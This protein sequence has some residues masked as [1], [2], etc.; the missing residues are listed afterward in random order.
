MAALLAGTLAA[1][2]LAG[3]LAA[4]TW[5][6]RERRGGRYFAA[7]MAVNALW[8]LGF[9]AEITATDL[10]AA[11]SWFRWRSAVIAFVP[12]LWTLFALEYA[13]Y[14]DRISPLVVAA[15][16]LPATVT[17]TLSF[18]NPIHGQ[19]WSDA[20]LV[21]EGPFRLLVVEYG[22]G[23]WVSVA[24]S[25]LFV[26]AGMILIA[27]VAVR[28]SGLYRKQSLL[29]LGASVAPCV[30]NASYHLG[31][32]P[33]PHLD[34]TPFGFVVNGVVVFWALYDYRLFDLSPVA[35]S[36]V[37]DRM[38]D[39]VVAVD[40]GEHVVDV[41]PAARDLSALTAPLGRQFLEAFPEVAAAVDVDAATTN[42][43]V[44][45]DSGGG[46][47]YFEPLVTPLDDGQGAVVI[48]RDVTRRRKREQ[49]L[50]AIQSASRDLMRAE[51]PDAVAEHTVDAVRDVLDLEYAAIHLAED[52]ELRPAAYTDAVLDLYDP[53]PAFDVGEGLQGSVFE[54]G[55]PIVYGDV[56]E[57]NALRDDE[58][59]V[60]GVAVF[61]LGDR[62]TLGAASTE[63]FEPDDALVRLTSV[64]ADNAAAALTR[65][66]REAELRERER[67]LAR[68]NEQLDEFA[69]VVSHDLRNPIS[70]ADGYLELAREE[71]D[72]DALDQVA[73]AIDRMERLT[74][75][76]LELARSGRVVTDPAAVSLSDAAAEAWENVDTG[77]ARLD[78]R[79]D[80]A[81][82][83]DR[84]RL[85]QL[86]ENLFRNSVEHGAPEETAEAIGEDTFYRSAA[87]DATSRGT[88][89]GPL[90][91]DAAAE[92]AVGDGASA[93]AAELSVTVGVLSGKRAVDSRSSADRSSPVGFYVEDDG[94]GIPPSE[95][96]AVYEWGYS[97]TSD[98]TGFG[99]AIVR[100]IAEAHGWSVRIAD[101]DG[102]DEPSA[103]G[104][105]RDLSGG[106]RFEITGV[107][108]E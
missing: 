96:D 65:A 84:R 15:V 60:R 102:G 4:V 9:A 81:V 56:R 10:A 99:L 19:F 87:D 24:A 42:E 106:A 63:P 13:D 86:F 73:D 44:A 62:G 25:Y 31:V 69:S 61:P 16:A 79:G 98:G 83:A 66:E 18:T 82:R 54:T 91:D 52:G 95:R 68:Q 29:V 17:A 70:V 90:S 105:G 32:S 33:V 8:L 37:V 27:G 22:V 41:N 94:P 36:A 88:A 14:E 59:P 97:S 12:A 35:R 28:S 7:M 11:L 74:D 103:G 21:T 45:F 2:L 100:E 93:A 38:D 5:K 50:E 40:G 104:D 3:G 49:S 72:V 6:R 67:E 55:E 23:W 26:T 76:L 46:V 85:L 39:P 47:R 58:T 64:L 20:A 92:G 53:V 107:A 51:T 71:G 108:V 48:L 1:T 89:D 77:G 57:T 75:D 43:V 34:L 80:A 78:V 30:A 101:A